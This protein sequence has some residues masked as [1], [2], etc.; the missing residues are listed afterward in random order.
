[1]Q[2]V[3]SA[4]LGAMAEINDQSGGLVLFPWTLVPSFIP[5]L[6]G[7][8]PFGVV[9]F[10]PLISIQIAV[11]FVFLGYTIW[12][13]GRNVVQDAPMGYLA[14][15][16]I[17]LGFYLFFKGQ[18]FGLFKLAM[19]AQPVI[20]LFLAQGFARFLFSPSP[21][22]RRR[23]RVVLVLFFLCTMP[24]D[25]YYSYAS[26][27]TYGGGLTEVVGASRLGVRFDPPKN[28]KYDAIES[29]ISNV[30]SA[31]MLSQ[32]TQGIDTRFLSRSYMDNIANIAV[33][34]FLRTPDPDLGPQARI[35]E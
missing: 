10:D 29:D 32:Y 6:F 27:G 34:K 19:F 8:H 17:P 2:S 7:L 25:I 22:F 14:A 4:G 5:M 16:M 31:K 21:Q 11:G 24:S 20:T 23:A 9:G 13:A 35:V 1:M 12:A 18:D 33:L 3:G 15:I 30:V 28:L 26:L